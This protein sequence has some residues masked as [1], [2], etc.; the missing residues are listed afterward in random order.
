MTFEELVKDPSPSWL[1]PGRKS[2]V[3]LS[4]IQL[5]RNMKDQPFPSGEGGKGRPAAAEAAREAVG[6]WNSHEENQLEELSL[7]KL[8]SVQKEVLEEKALITPN[9]VS[10]SDHNALY[11]SRDG[12]FSVL[13]NGYDH[14]R[15]QMI[16]ADRDLKKMWSDM[17]YADDM[18][19]QKI[20]YAFDREFG[21]LTASPEWTGTGLRVSSVIFIPGIVASKYLTRLAQ[22]TVKLGFVL[23][24]LFGR[25]AGANG[26]IFEMTSQI[27]MGIS[28]EQLVSRL[29][30]LLQ[31]IEQT[32]QHCRDKL[33][34]TKGRDMRDALWRSVG[35]LKY[36]RQMTQ[37]EAMGHI[38]RL[39][40]GMDEGLISSPGSG[41]FQ[42]LLAC[43]LP[44]RIRILTGQDDMDQDAENTC[45]A[46]M[47]R[48]QMKNVGDQEEQN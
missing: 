30:D 3:L 33:L 41:F 42:Q 2:C 36:A 31:D 34:K 5:A 32:E 24:G 4:R 25:D 44:A 15:F 1:D 45:R 27:S 40:L 10:Q 6:F 22:S 18:F 8:S 17:N 13:V 46:S 26:C 19:G 48:R 23:H 11:V 7:M 39:R 9:L 21:Y 35:L 37:E 14:F 43:T 38:C 12:S 28:E 16:R 20:Q 47:L 29:E